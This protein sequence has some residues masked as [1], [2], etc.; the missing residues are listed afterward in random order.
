LKKKKR[1][2]LTGGESRRGVK[3][4]KLI[5]KRPGKGIAPLDERKKRS[6][7][8]RQR[9]DPSRLEKG[10][11]VMN[12]LLQNARTREKK[13]RRGLR[14]SVHYPGEKGGRIF[15]G[16]KGNFRSSQGGAKG[17]DTKRK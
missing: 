14:R 3:A 7:G 8:S 6:R 10:E 17:P 9:G 5:R 13:S 4:E 16:E 15:N 2:T 11:A 1:R 12:L